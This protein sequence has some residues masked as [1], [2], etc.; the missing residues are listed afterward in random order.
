MEVNNSR[1]VCCQHPVNVALTEFLC[2]PLE[3]RDMALARS[4][5]SELRPFNSEMCDLAASLFNDAGRRRGSLA[6]CMIAATA[7]A[8]HAPLATCNQADFVAFRSSGLL[9]AKDA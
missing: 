1:L 8:E 5:I 2:G 6:D 4:I 9:L 7:I 3:Q